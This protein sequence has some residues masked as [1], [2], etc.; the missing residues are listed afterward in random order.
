VDERDIE[1]NSLG[2]DEV[3][4][5]EES[6][7]TQ[8]SEEA[9]SDPRYL[10]QKPALP[11]R[12]GGLSASDA[13]ALDRRALPDDEVAHVVERGPLSKKTPRKDDESGRP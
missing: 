6:Q 7:E 5:S 9:S 13:L 12:K 2:L 8:A 11:D 10:E 1:N 3:P 4:K